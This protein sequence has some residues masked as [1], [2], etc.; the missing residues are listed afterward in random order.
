MV[1][2]ALNGAWNSLVSVAVVQFQRSV[3]EN[4]ANRSV[5]SKPLTA[6]SGLLSSARIQRSGL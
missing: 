5:E 4:A 1:I 3:C 6:R 2:P